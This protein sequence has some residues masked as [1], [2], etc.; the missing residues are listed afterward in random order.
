MS[1]E[2]R[3]VK[4]IYMPKTPYER[5]A[6]DDV[7]L[8]LEE[9]SFTAIAGHTGSG[10]STLVQHLNGLLSPAAGEVLVDGVNINAK[11]KEGKIKA[12]H[13]RQQVGMVFQYAETQLFE[14]TIAQDIAFGPQ[15]QGLEENEVEERVR[16]AMELVGLDYHKFKD[17]SPFALSGGQMRRVAMAGV[18]AMRPKYL[19]LDEP[20]AGLDPR[21]RDELMAEIQRLHKKWKLTIVFVS[22][23]ME[24]IAKMADKMVVMQGGKL[25]AAGSPM[26]IFAQDSMLKETGLEKPQIMQIMERLKQAGLPVNVEAITPEAGLKSLGEVFHLC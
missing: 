22:H 3:N 6:L 9:G 25:R 19:V 10:K 23:S 5:M 1:I 4:Y 17:M 18:L 7:T 20:A 8:T 16:Q 12:W 13:A 15:N 2:L 26:E 21:G 24:D 14:E 11:D